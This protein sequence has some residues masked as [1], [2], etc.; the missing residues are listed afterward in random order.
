MSIVQYSSS[1]RERSVQE[2]LNLAKIIAPRYGVTRVTNITQLDRIG[3]PVFAGVNPSNAALA[4]L[5]GKG[6]TAAE[7][8]VGAYMES[9]EFALAE[10]HNSSASL[11]YRSIEACEAQLPANLK[12]KDFCI[13]YGV[14][15][16]LTDIIAT[17]TAHD[18]VSGK[19]CEL[20][21]ELFFHPLQKT[22]STKLFGTSSNGL[23]SGNS[24]DE[25]TLHALFEVLERDAEA[26]GRYSNNG[27]RKV[28][29]STLPTHIKE[30]CTQI[31]NADLQL[32][33]RSYDSNYGVPFFQA[34]VKDDDPDFPSIASGQ[35]AHFDASIAVT[36]A[37]TEAVQSRMSHIHGGR[38][39]L[40]A[41]LKSHESLYSSSRKQAIKALSD[42]LDSN[43]QTM[44]FNDVK[45]IYLNRESVHA[46]LESVKEFLRTKGIHQIFRV[47]HTDPGSPLPVVKIVVPLLEHFEIVNKRVGPRLMEKLARG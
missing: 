24:E 21:A 37:I 20:P 41:R 7:A 8:Q 3:I 12:I 26:H 18:I 6:I 13:A 25:A 17:T 5:A 32:E 40:D 23:A 29:Y 11:Q 31:E 16:A 47:V 1:L 39:D 35:G 34:F 44:D 4:V 22:R 15:P 9:Y 28:K 33:L 27:Y 14:K 42:S 38:D 30:L 43:N 2:T 46:A 10:P 36:R 19:Q 45:S